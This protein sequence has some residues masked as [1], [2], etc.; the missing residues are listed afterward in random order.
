MDWKKRQPIRTIVDA[1][2]L[3]AI[4]LFL[5]CYFEP[6][7][8]LSKTTLTGGDTGAHYFTA[9]YLRDY[10]LPRGKISG[11]CQGN[12]AGFPM[13]QYYFPLPF[14]IMAALSWAI[15]LQIAF[16]LVTVMGI[17]LLPVCTYFFFRFLKQPFPVPA[18]GAVFSVAF[19]FMEGNTMWGGNIASTLSGEFCYSVGFA[20]SVLWLGLLYYNI[21]QNRG[22]F[23]SSILL[24]LVGFCHGY[25][26]LFVVFASAFF[27][28]FP[29]HFRRN[30][31]ILLRIH[32]A[33]L[34]LMSFWLL[35][36]VVFLPHSTR[37][38][39]LW[40][41][42]DWQQI[43]REVFPVV[44]YPFLGLSFAGSAWAAS[45]AAKNRDSASIKPWAYVCYLAACGLALFAAGYR[46]GVVDVR[47]LPFF[48]FFLA[49]GGAMIFAVVPIPAKADVLAAFLVLVLALLWVDSRETFVKNWITSNYT[50]FEKKPLWPDFSETNRF[51]KGSP[52]H[53][54]VVYEHSMLHN[55]TGSV[56]AFESLPLF[57]GRS[58]LE[59]VY[60]Q[61]SLCVPFIFYLQSEI[62]QNASNP[63]PDYNYSRFNLRR[64]VEH[65]QLFNVRHFIA[66]E[67]RTKAAAM[68]FPGFRLRHRAGPYDVFEYLP[69]SDRYVEALEHK[70]VLCTSDDWRKI[71][72]RW[73][74]LGD[75]SVHMVFKPTIDAQDRKR[76]IIADLSDIR[77]LPSVP[78]ET[79]APAGEIIEQE[80]IRIEGAP[81]GKP[82][83]IKVSYHPNWKVE[84]ADRIYLA[85][86]AFML[87]YPTASRVRL[88]YGRTWP[89]YAGALITGITLLFALLSLIF[90]FKAAGSTIEN[91]F[92]RYGSQTA[93]AVIGALLIAFFYYLVYLSPEFPV[94]EYNRGIEHFTRGDYDQAQKNFE[95][96]IERHPQTLIADQA[97]YHLAMCFFRQNDWDGTIKNLKRLLETYPETPRASE[98]GYHLGLCY[99]NAGRIEAARKQFRQTIDEFGDETWAR[100]ANDRL[101]EMPSP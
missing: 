20:L 74:R 87:V 79:H 13:L 53:P 29:K 61:A 50:G 31:K 98:A 9:Q 62:S 10:L 81:V 37:F 6:A 70:P 33:A 97:A 38:S 18:I 36:L 85:S 57:A 16:K 94:L 51:L 21:S 58:T 32:L 24:A 8:L 84:G 96:V 95:K 63:I 1:V 55:R 83:L 45:K 73:F 2:T 69:N 22:F 72:Y 86:P 40:I 71:S 11:W 35:P 78:L 77:R 99:M 44:L 90:D 52:Q 43:S 12:L 34:F 15:P 65:F 91:V 49:V 48:Q 56:R 80:E 60:I 41:F 67:E 5:L 82:L 28:F 101:K 23:V 75:L 42:F 64:A 92:D 66:S 59:G 88:Y 26:L 89:D 76:F 39:I 27:L 54:R 47:F 4:F 3:I 19:L 93:L 17:F 68:N 30:L 14:V 46:M 100:F 7:Y 25:T